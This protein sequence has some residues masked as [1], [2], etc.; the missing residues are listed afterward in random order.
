MGVLQLVQYTYTYTEAIH[1][2]THIDDYPRMRVLIICFSKVANLCG[3]LIDE[4]AAELASNLHDLVKTVKV[5]EGIRNKNL[6][7][8]MSVR[9]LELK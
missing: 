4:E 7:Y 1:S 5:P 9:A 2:L 6:M 8:L 3:D